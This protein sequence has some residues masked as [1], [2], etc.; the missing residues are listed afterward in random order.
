MLYN[1]I[2]DHVWPLVSFDNIGLGAF[3]SIGLCEGD[4]SFFIS[5]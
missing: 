2:Y 3:S 1:I 5:F 4:K